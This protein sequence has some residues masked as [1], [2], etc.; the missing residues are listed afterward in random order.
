VPLSLAGT[1]LQNSLVRNAPRHTSTLPIRDV[2]CALFVRFWP[3]I[4]SPP[5]SPAR[6]AAQIKGCEQYEGFIEALGGG[7]RKARACFKS[8]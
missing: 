8:D 4:T 6:A 1:L 7:C 2:D 5:P 3:T